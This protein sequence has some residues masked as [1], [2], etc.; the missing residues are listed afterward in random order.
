MKQRQQRLLGSG[1]E[2]GKAVAV[3]IK[4]P[5]NLLIQ[6]LWIFRLTPDGDDANGNT[7]QK[8][9]WVP[10]VPIKLQKQTKIMGPRHEAMDIDKVTVITIIISFIAPL[11]SLHGF[12]AGMLRRSLTNTKSMSIGNIC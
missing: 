12:D 1:G 8:S 7:I 2:E 4:K 3:S 11:E 9:L 10:C 5:T 6:L